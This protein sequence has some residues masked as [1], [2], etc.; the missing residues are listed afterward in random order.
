MTVFTGSSEQYVSTCTPEPSSQSEMVFSVFAKAVRDRFNELTKYPLVVVDVPSEAM[1]D[2]YLK[3]FGSDD[4]IFRKRAGHDCSCCRHFIR[5]VG[6]VVALTP[7]GMKTIWPTSIP[8]Q[9]VYERVSNAMNDLILSGNVVD[10]FLSGY[11]TAGQ[12]L[13]RTEIEGRVH[14][15]NHF[16]VDIPSKFQVNRHSLQSELGDKRTTV[17]MFKRALDEITSGAVDD[18]LDLIRTDALYRGAEHM[19]NVDAFCKA[20]EAYSKQSDPNWVWANAEKYKAIARIRN[21]VI[22]SL[23]V[24]LSEGRDLESAVKSFE[25]KVA[26]TNYKRPKALVT[27]RMVED[28]KAKVAELGLEGALERRHANLTDVSVNNVLFA[29]RSAR[30]VM[31]G[32]GAFDNIPTKKSQKNFDRVDSMP[33]EQFITDVL[34]TAT[35]LD[36]LLEN[37]HSRNLVSLVTAVDQG[38][39]RLF[40][41]DNPF[42]WSYNGDLADSD[43]R[44]AVQ[45]RGGRV[46]GVFRFSHSWNYDRRN[47]SLMDLHVFFPAHGPQG[48]GKH[49]NYGNLARV[50]WNARTHRASGAVQD[51]DYTQPAPA[52]YIP[53]ENITFPNLKTM[54]D[55]QYQC[56]IHN[57]QKRAPNEGG[58]R[59]EI[60]FGG[61][62]YEYEHLKPLDH[63]E[64]V[65]V[66]TVTK[67]GDKF[68]ISHAMPCG[69]SSQAVWGVTTGDFVRVNAVMRSPNY[70]DEQKGGGNEHIFFMIDGCVAEGDVRGFYNEFLRG[71]LEPHRKVLELVGSRQRTAETENQL[72][73]I[74]FSK[75]SKAEL[76]VRVTGASVT[77]TLKLTF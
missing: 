44:S 60:E 49:D 5:D 61:E 43:I 73:G 70:W 23:L 15:F 74:G 16:Q 64:W 77:R 4:P 53:V 35:S 30:S 2:T 51:V 18:V 24:D 34:P 39:P 25:D 56:M 9:P 1:W 13:S 76:V 40:K 20:Q 72:S 55:G 45:A 31:K 21:T 71:E 69:S 22:G 11:P 59:A 46:D 19:G 65:H 12:K 48:V 29:D 62:V 28:A 36:V 50:G 3:T 6:N 10:F 58:F 38:A 75:T 42:S 26:P 7:S 37:K 32:G 52:G 41:W 47:A 54:P 8:G 68:S 57:W 67:K 27:P 17:Q 33:I 14:T 63:K 66:A